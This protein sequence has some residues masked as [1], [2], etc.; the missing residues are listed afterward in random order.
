MPQPSIENEYPARGWLYV[1]TRSVWQYKAGSNDQQRGQA[2]FEFDVGALRKIDKGV[3]FMTIENTDIL[4]AGP[5]DVTGRV[6]A[7]VLT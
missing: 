3:L 7:L 2:V 5:F 4:G 1:A 6:R